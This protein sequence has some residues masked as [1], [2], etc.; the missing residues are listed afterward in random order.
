MG[1]TPRGSWTSSVFDLRN[2]QSDPLIRSLLDRIPVDQIDK[3]NENN[4]H[5]ARQ[6]AFFSLYP[7]QEEEDIIERRLNAEM[8]KE[9]LGHRILVKCLA[10]K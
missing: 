7:P 1:D 10:L 8:P 3:V 4:R 9:H 2:S 5:E 6:E